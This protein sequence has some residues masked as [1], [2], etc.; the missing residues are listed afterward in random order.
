VKYTIII[1]GKGY[2]T[3]VHEVDEKVFSELTD[4]YQQDEL[5]EEK[6]KALMC[7]EKYL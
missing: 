4:A 3:T 6:V 1:L 7:V 2:N 5:I